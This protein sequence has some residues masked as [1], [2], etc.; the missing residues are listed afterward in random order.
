[1]GPSLNPA[2][3]RLAVEVEDHPVEYADFEGVIPEGNY[4]AGEVIGWDKG[5]GRDR[6]SDERCRSAR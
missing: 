2:D 3:K 1:M 5:C 4:G 6:E